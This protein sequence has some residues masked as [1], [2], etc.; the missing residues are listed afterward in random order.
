MGIKGFILI[1]L[2]VLIVVFSLQ[3]LQ[4]ITLFFF[5]IK[6]ISLPLSLAILLFIF[7]GLISSLII[8]F[9]SKFS[10][11]K[12]NSNRF[13]NKRSPTSPPPTSEE[14]YSPRKEPSRENYPDNRETSTNR[15][16][17]QK[18]AI[19]TEEKAPIEPEFK[20][21]KSANYL[22]KFPQDNNNYQEQIIRE[23]EDI[24]EAIKP[25]KEVIIDNVADSNLTKNNENFI[26]PEEGITK[27]RQAAPYSYQPK[28]KTEI[29]P[30]N[31]EIKRKKS[32][33]K[34]PEVENGIYNAPY[35]V[36]TP[37]NEGDSSRYQPEDD[38]DDWDF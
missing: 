9:L 3:N 30:E 2:L 26:S 14:Y 15:E 31:Y 16:F 27:P 13:D 34:R 5:G 25:D 19:K 23:E 38:D 21:N 8:Q 11:N 33:K 1:L 20:V 6:T 24:S 4:N 10:A 32:G 29:F 28:E 12:S 36:I 22:E 7:A 37:A 35:R 18:S 17:N